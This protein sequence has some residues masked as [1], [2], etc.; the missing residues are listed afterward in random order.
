MAVG[1]AGSFRQW[2][3]H[4]QRSQLFSA[5]DLHLLAK[6]LAHLLGAGVAVRDAL[7]I[8]SEEAQKRDQLQFYLNLIAALDRGDSFSQGLQRWVPTIPQFFVNSLKAGEASGQGEIVFRQLADYYLQEEEIRRKV[9]NALL[10][11]AF[12]LV[13]ALGVC[14]FLVSFVIPGFTSL[15]GETPQVLPFATRLLLGASVFLQSFWPVILALLFATGLTVRFFWS[16]A[17]FRRNAEALLYRLPLFGPLAFKQ[18]WSHFSRTLALLLGSG[19]EMLSSIDLAAEVMGSLLLRQ[20]IFAASK[21]VRLG[22]SFS[23]SLALLPFLPQGFLS[24]LR[25]GENGA[26]L[27]P[28]LQEAAAYYD[29]EIRMTYEK[30]NRLIEPVL[31]LIISLFIGFIAMAILLPMLNQWQGISQI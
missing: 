19:N 21:Q 6:Q 2:L 3:D 17:G 11:P 28:L 22:R 14:L 31:I 7:V 1:A 25:I 30:I 15:Y 13:V 23:A 29:L 12:L 10:Y 26:G 24:M 4:L 27:A 20:G 5:Y 9:Q 8:L 18:E 16:Q